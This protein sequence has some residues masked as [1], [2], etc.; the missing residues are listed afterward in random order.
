MSLNGSC[1][2]RSS[3]RL[4]AQS[5]VYSLSR[6]SSRKPATTLFPCSKRN[7]ASSHPIHHTFP[8]KPPLTTQ[9][10]Q[11]NILP[12]IHTYIH[13]YAPKRPPPPHWSTSLHAQNPALPSPQ[14]SSRPHIYMITSPHHESHPPST[15]YSPYLG[16]FNLDKYYTSIHKP[17]PNSRT[18]PAHQS[19]HP[20]PLSARE[21]PSRW[22]LSKRT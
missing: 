12:S 20:V 6:S 11:V 15:I 22:N 9:D 19:M 3:C 2:H 18:F 17:K 21:L 5:R 10:K 7:P 14:P 1:M 13:T 16:R 4:K 8:S